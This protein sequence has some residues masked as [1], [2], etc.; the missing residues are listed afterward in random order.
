M[1]TPRL[2]ELSC[3]RCLNLSHASFISEWVRILDGADFG[4]WGHNGVKSYFKVC[5][6]F[7]S[8]KYLH[9]HEVLMLNDTKEFFKRSSAERFSNPG[10]CHKRWRGSPVLDR[11]VN[12]LP[13]SGG[14]LCPPHYPLDFQTFLWSCVQGGGDNKRMFIYCSV[15]FSEPPNFGG[16]FR[17]TFSSEI[18]PLFSL[19]SMNI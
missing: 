9:L 2:M 15:L 6:L 17:S 1:R 19:V 14:T 5:S 16:Q 10:Q 13:T 7:F 8:D 3:Y 18:L 4:V 11:S 12:P